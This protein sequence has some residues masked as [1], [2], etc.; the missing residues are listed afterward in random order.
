MQP[1]SKVK[2]D[3]I[4]HWGQGDAMIHRPNVAVKVAQYIAHW[5]DIETLLGLFLSLLLHAHE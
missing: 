2:P 4:T 1:L 3:A 5:S